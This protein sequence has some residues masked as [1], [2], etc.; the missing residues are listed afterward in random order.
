MDPNECLKVI[1]DRA[2]EI[3]ENSDTNYSVASCD[4]LELAESVQNL[5]EWIRDGGFLPD[6]W[7]EGQAP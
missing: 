1:L 3:V 7:L 2:R 5:D 4:A 6:A